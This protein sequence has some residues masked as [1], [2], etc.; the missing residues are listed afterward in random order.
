MKEMKDN[1]DLKLNM[2][3]TMIRLKEKINEIK[4]LKGNDLTEIKIEE[5]NQN[6]NNINQ[7]NNN[8]NIE[9][10]NQNNNNEIILKEMEERFTIHDEN[11]VSSE[12]IKK[13]IKKWVEGQTFLIG[14][15]SEYNKKAYNLETSNYAKEGHKII[16]KNL[17]E[18]KNEEHIPNL[19]NKID[20]QINKLNWP[21]LEK[22]EI[23]DLKAFLQIM[24]GI[25]LKE[26]DQYYKYL[27]EKSEKKEGRIIISKRGKVKVSLNEK[28][29]EQIYLLKKS[30]LFIK[31][32]TKRY[33]LKKIFK[34]IVTLISHNFCWVCYLFMI[35]NHMA[36]ASL[37]SL[38][39][40]LSI[41]CYAIYQN[42]RP[43]KNYWQICYYFTLIFT[44]IKIIFQEIYLGSV[45]LFGKEGYIPSQTYGRFKLFLDYNQIGIKLYDTYKDYYLN[46]TLDFLVLIALIINK[47]IL[48]I[49]G[50]WTYNEEYYENIKEANERVFN[51]QE[52][53]LKD[54]FENKKIRIK[55]NEKKC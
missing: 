44:I 32:L 34:D 53:N 28:A 54:I 14:K 52:R 31:Y 15:Y 48:L 7:N 1:L 40:P 23:K 6:N 4:E 29:I 26:L 27:K 47:N 19:F 21:D 9:N 39:Y 38:F 24:D 33:L 51:K 37:I 16:K 5:K 36:N 18:G 8:I 41:F 43:S 17:I 20:Q 11:K 25:G 22:K 10:N 13:L 3:R 46:L 49:N 42:P 2:E 50:L 12:D 45:Y 55:I 35:L 30:P